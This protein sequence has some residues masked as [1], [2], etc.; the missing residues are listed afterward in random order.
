MMFAFLPG[1]SWCYSIKYFVQRMKCKMFWIFKR[2]TLNIALN[3]DLPSHF[4][5]RGLFLWLWA[6]RG[7]RQLWEVSPRFLQ[8][9]NQALFLS[10]MSQRKDHTWHRVNVW[11]WLLSGLV[12]VTYITWQWHHHY[13][14]T[15]CNCN[16]VINVPIFGGEMLWPTASPCK[17]VL[18]AMLYIVM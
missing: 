2:T 18:P 12:D 13:I 9:P 15:T 8:R 17:S 4:S 7:N 5:N 11:V 14:S 1:K 10:T 3:V 6:G 16:L